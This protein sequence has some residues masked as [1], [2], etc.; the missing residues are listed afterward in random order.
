[1]KETHKFDWSE[2]PTSALLGKMVKVLAQIRKE[3]PENLSSHE[4][5]MM[6]VLFWEVK[7]VE[8]AL[9]PDIMAE[10]MMADMMAKET[11]TDMFSL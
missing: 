10:M 7:L 9:G 11:G 3:G 8:D 6:A 1:M 4:S 5:Y 2:T